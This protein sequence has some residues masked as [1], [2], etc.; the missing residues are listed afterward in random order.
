MKHILILF[1]LKIVRCTADSNGNIRRHLAL[2]HGK[3][4]L[5][6][7]S[8]IIRRATLSA[9]KKRLLDKAAV[10]CI[11]IDARCWG[12]FKRAG[13]T[14][15]L[16]VAVPDYTGPSSRTV[17]RQLSK[18][19][20]EKAREFK[21]KLMEARNVSITADLW[22]TK[23]CQHYLCIT[24]HWLDPLFN[25][26]A[27]VLSFRQ[28]K[29]REFA[30]RLRR[31]I[32]RVLTHYNLMGKITATVTDNGANI[33]AASNAIRS[34]GIRFHCLA[35]ALN[36]VVH[37]SLRLWPKKKSVAKQNKNNVREET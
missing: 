12:D 29:G 5:A 27:K 8:H 35:H 9:E 22:R 23:R 16:S 26:K 21:E 17:Q 1:C 19:Y 13:M 15:F 36:L 3:I 10:E 2:T 31:H 7:K 34:F 33:K 24:I 18:L 20:V 11:I 4:H 37:K 30:V 25:L 6:C 14:K 32:T 28:F